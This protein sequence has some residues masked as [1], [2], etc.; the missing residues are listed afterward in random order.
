MAKCLNAIGED[1]QA[2]VRRHDTCRVVQMC[3][4]HGNEQQQTR[5]IEEMKEVFKELACSKYSIHLATKVYKL[6]ENKEELAFK[7]IPEARKIISQKEGSKFLQVLFETK[8]RPALLKS[9][10]GGAESSV[11]S[12]YLRDFVTEDEKNLEVVGRIVGKCVAKELQGLNVVQVVMLQYLECVQDL[13]IQT[14]LLTRLQPSLTSLMDTRAG[15]RLSILSLSISDNKTRKSLL[16][17]VKGHLHQLCMGEYSFLFVIKLLHT[18]DDTKRIGSIVSADINPALESIISVNQGVKVIVSLLFDDYKKHLSQ[19]EWELLEE[20][21]NT[22]SK[23]DPFLRRKELLLVTL[24]L[25]SHII[26][27]KIRDF[28]QDSLRTSLILGYSEAIITKIWTDSQF[29]TEFS[30]LMRVEEVLNNAI[31]QRTVK[32]IV[33]FEAENEISVFAEGILSVL[34]EE[35]REKMVK[36]RGVWILVALAEKSKIREKF[37]KLFS[38]K[39]LESLENGQ[40]GEKAL[41]A[42]LR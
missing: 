39:E 1:L 11:E 31:S 22:T 18:I 8:Y 12:T 2:A 35:N 21:Y 7:I 19:S 36:S 4:K 6:T 29:I 23:K 9:L 40:K 28:I 41:A 30:K 20:S 17:T 26:R 33:E 16:K 27:T 10:F 32:K 42:A 34:T 5:I 13:S 3:L 24:P 37:A 38:S 25:L 14:D 15:V